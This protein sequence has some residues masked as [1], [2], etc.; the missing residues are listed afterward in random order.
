MRR[1]CVGLLPAPPARI[2]ISVPARTLDCFKQAAKRSAETTE[3]WIVTAAW[4]WFAEQELSRC[5]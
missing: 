1:T 4:R 2:T 3:D 5:Q